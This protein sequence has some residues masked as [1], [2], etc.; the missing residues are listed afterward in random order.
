MPPSKQ[1]PKLELIPKV[2]EAASLQLARQIAQARLR[3]IV[4][5]AEGHSTA[6]SLARATGVSQSHM[7]NVLTG[8]RNLTPDLADK[9]NATID[10]QQRRTA[11]RFGGKAA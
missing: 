11:P 10:L 2:A 3:A 7:T 4:H 5:V 9:L 1:T 8:R 6:S